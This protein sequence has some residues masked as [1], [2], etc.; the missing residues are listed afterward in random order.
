MHV[1]E[2][3]IPSCVAKRIPRLVGR[4][5]PSLDIRAPSAARTH[6]LLLLGD[7]D[8]HVLLD[9]KARNALVA[10]ARV[11]GGKDLLGR[12]PQMKRQLALGSDVAGRWSAVY[13][14]VRGRCR[15]LPSL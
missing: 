10:L 1:D 3:R 8:S 7:L 6:L 2:A 11:D 9:D 15:L 5:Y 14:Y 13:G 4:V 12:A